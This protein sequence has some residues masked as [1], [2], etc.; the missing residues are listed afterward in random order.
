MESDIQ[1][2]SVDSTNFCTKGTHLL[3]KYSD[4]C[5]NCIEIEY[6]KSLLSSHD[7]HLTL[8]GEDGC[9]CLPIREKLSRLES[10]EY[11]I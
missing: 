9:Q 5:R 6:L 7:C 10:Q 2:I 11:I 1:K 4:E 3:T 8:I